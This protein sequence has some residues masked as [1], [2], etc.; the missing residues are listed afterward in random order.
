MKSELQV[1]APVS[2]VATEQSYLQIPSRPEWIA[3]TV[4]FLKEK[5]ILCGICHEAR[6]K[7]LMLALHEALTNSIIHGNLE[8]PSDLKERSDDAFAEALAQRA[9]DPRYN[10]RTVEVQIDYDGERCHW[11]LTDQGKGFDVERVLAEASSIGEEEMLLTSGRGIVLMRALLDDVRYE[12]NGRRAILTL[13]RHSGEEKRR[14]PRQ[15]LQLPIRVAP[16]IGAMLEQLNGSLVRHDERRL[17][18][19]AAYTARITIETGPE[20]PALIGFGRDL[21]RGGIAFLTSSPLPLENVIL[22]L[23]QPDCKSLRV[24]ARV[25][26]CHQILSGIYDVGA[27]FVDVV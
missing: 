5:A 19:R 17:H 15:A 21:S 12:L 13:A 7:K 27:R 6:A 22:T 10:Q 9:A 14:A 20:Q 24:L 4:E 16:I 26:R 23:P 3:P 11:I 2:A 1:P 18:P 8:L 25:V